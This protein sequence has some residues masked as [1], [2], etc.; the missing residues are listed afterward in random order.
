MALTPI[1]DIGVA[2]LT[3]LSSF[4]G[5]G[6]IAG[7]QVHHDAT[8]LTGFTDGDNIGTWPD[9]TGNGY[10]M[11]Q[12]DSGEQPSYAA[13]QFNGNAAVRFAGGNDNAEFFT[14]SFPT[15][16]SEGDFFVVMVRDQYP[17]EDGE[18]TNWSYGT[19]SGSPHY[20][21]TDGD[22]YLAWGR[23]E[24]AIEGVTP[25]TGLDQ[26][27]L[28][29]IQSAT[30]MVAIQNGV[31]Q[32]MT[33]SGNVDFPSTPYLGMNSGDDGDNMR[34]MAGYICE[35]AIYDNVISSSDRSDLEQYFQD[36]WGFSF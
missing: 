19:I 17:P 10:D 31:Q 18:Q 33:T 30:E 34:G 7:L 21:F 5:P 23:D 24:R 1:G 3:E 4:T 25:D 20:T 22:M 29:E 16:I 32:A 14:G 36:K 6:D 11:T 9:E 8:E 27:H 2:D 13:S 15:G 28:L 35:V 26:L 12:G